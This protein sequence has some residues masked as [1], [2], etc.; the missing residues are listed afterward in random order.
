MIQKIGKNGD[1]KTKVPF[2]IS[3]NLEIIEDKEKRYDF[4]QKKL[5]QKNNKKIK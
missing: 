2:C 3:P 5:N 4:F 1:K